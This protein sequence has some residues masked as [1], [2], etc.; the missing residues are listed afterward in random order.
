MD[1]RILRYFVTVA[2]EGTISQ[3][4]RVL[5]VS[6][7]TLSKQLMEL[8]EELDLTLFMRGNRN[9]TLTQDGLFFLGKAKEILHL[10]DHTLANLHT[11]K[12]LTGQL[13]IGLNE[14]PNIAYLTSTFKDIQKQNPDTQ[15]HLQGMTTEIAY[16]KLDQGLLDFV[17]TVGSMTSDHYQHLQLPVQDTACLVLPKD[18]PLAKKTSIRGKDLID[19]PLIAFGQKSGYQDLANWLGTSLEQ[20]NIVASF[21]LPTIGIQMVQAGLGLAFNLE[22]F[23]LPEDLVSRPLHPLATPH[24]QLLWKKEQPLSPLAQE[25][26]EQLKRK[27]M[28]DR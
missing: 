9:I 11:S 26:L 28:E 8:E 20:L 16:E 27:G 23:S 17:V 2:N 1:L 10:V 18:H 12:T 6:Q 5:H 7:P 19:Q 14:T 15:I 24:L 25:F 22:G 3:A 4:A 13:T 21:N